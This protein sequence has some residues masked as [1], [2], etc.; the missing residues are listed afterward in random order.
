MALAPGVSLYRMTRIRPAGLHDLPGAYRVCLL[1]GDGGRDGSA[2]FRN[3]DLI[4]HVYVG[5][6]IVGQP[7]LALVL[8]DPEGVA[9]Y[10][11]AA[12]GTR[13]FEAW[14]EARW[15]P[16]LREQ[17]PPTDDDS[18]DGE[19]VRLLHAPQHA[20]EAVVRDYPAHLHIDLLERVRGLGLGRI[21]VETQVAA[22][23]ERGSRGLHLDVAAD[24]SNA[25][26][27]YRHLGFAEVHRRETSILMGMRLA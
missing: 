16:P 6:Y 1:T 14:E 26:D 19:L 9:G 7:E 15:W 2:L 13:A 18:P 11:L 12:E 8:V 24:N 3:P 20:P 23:R 21:L 4:G 25:I 17:Y 10:C 5:P 27:F 22:L